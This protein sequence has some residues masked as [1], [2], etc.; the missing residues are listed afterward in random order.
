MKRIIY[1]TIAILALA[2]CTKR[3][4][5]TF[6]RPEGQDIPVDTT[7]SFDAKVGEPLP[8][9]TEGVL[10]IHA[11][12]TGRGECTFFILPDATT[13]VVDAGDLFN[14]SNTSY[15]NVPARPSKSIEPYKVLGDYI[16]HFL[17][18]GHSQLD[19][20]VLTHYH[21]DHMGYLG[22]GRTTDSRGGY[23]LAGVT[24]LYSIVPFL[25]LIDRSYP[26]Y[27][28]TT[29][30]DADK[31]DFYTSFVN[32]AVN[33]YSMKAERFDVG[34]KNQITLKY[35][36]SDYEFSVQNLAGSGCVWD[37]KAV[38]DKKMTAENALSTAFLLSY[39]KFDYFTSGD[40]NN[41]SVCEPLANAV[42]HEIEAEKALHHMSNESPFAVQNKV[43]NSK[44]V[45]TQSFYVRADQ[46]QQSMI[47]LYS[48][49]KDMF[50]TGIDESLLTASPDVYKNCKG[51]NGHVV[52]RVAGKGEYF[53]VYMLDDTNSE[54]RVKSIHGPY[55]CK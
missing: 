18:S 29:V 1:F 39:G 4:S 7:G 51:I 13:M 33:N 48:P 8:A 12:S 41:N 3:P 53:Y 30:G 37:G 47:N 5:P 32:Y 24:G 22:S 26:D 19:Y 52:I 28:S 17:P 42:G 34:S 27:S 40:L 49:S 31:I 38:V 55:T 9:W 15:G 46:P 44:V 21:I 6:H 2:A 50:F 54:Y 36:P 16:N 43:F 23:V 14:Y 20:F 35:K 11:I 25:T 45:V 10:D